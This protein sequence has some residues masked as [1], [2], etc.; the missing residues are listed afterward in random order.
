M[1]RPRKENSSASLVVCLFHY[2]TSD[3]ALVEEDSEMPNLTEVFDAGE[4]RRQKVGASDFVNDLVFEL[5]DDIEQELA[6]EKE[7]QARAARI[8]AFRKGKDTDGFATIRSS[9]SASSEVPK[10]QGKSRKSEAE[11][12]VSSHQKVAAQLSSRGSKLG[13]S[14][15]T[16]ANQTIS[17]QQSSEDLYLWQMKQRDKTRTKMTREQEEKELR[18]QADEKLQEISTTGLEPPKKLAKVA[19]VSLKQVFDNLEGIPAEEWRAKS[20][21]LLAGALAVDIDDSP[22]ISQRDAGERALA[23]EKALFELEFSRTPQAA[24]VPDLDTSD[25]GTN[26]TN[27]NTAINPAATRLVETFRRTNNADDGV[28]QVVQSDDPEPRNSVA[29]YHADTFVEEFDSGA[30]RPES[31][32][33]RALLM[34]K[35]KAMRSSTSSGGGGGADSNAKASYTD[36]V[37]TLLRNLRVPGNHQLRKNVLSGQLDSEA[38]VLAKAEDL[39]DPEAAAKWQRTKEELFNRSKVVDPSDALA[40]TTIVDTA[41]CPQCG[42]TDKNFMLVTHHQESSKCEIWGNKD[43]RNDM[44]E[45]FRCSKCR[46]NF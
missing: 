7:R 1:K 2:Y 24:A 15:S 43:D 25:A 45:R 22:G 10:S 32:T 37:R 44:K 20:A 18:R 38:L 34:L 5:E 19:P 46:R 27:I 40:S 9:H 36:K 28:E 17:K 31:R 30:N 41:L 23:I 33:S 13:S 12:S 6:A 14:S 11:K 29:G 35:R 42:N 21:S 39:M 4:Y 8:D 26:N 16:S 3:A